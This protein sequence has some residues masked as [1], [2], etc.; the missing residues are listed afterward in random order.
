M[1]IVFLPLL[2]IRRRLDGQFSLE[3]FLKLSD[4]TS[5]PIFAMQK[6]ISELF[7]ENNSH[8]CH[9]WANYLAVYERHLSPFRGKKPVVLEIGVKRG[10]SLALWK[11]YF[12]PES[13]IIGIDIDPSCERFQSHGLDVYIGDQ[14]DEVFLE[15]V[16]SAYQKIDI[17]I[18]DGSHVGSHMIK[19][20]EYIYPRMSNVGIYVVEDVVP[21]V[22][23]SASG[24]E[25]RSF[26]DY[27]CNLANHLNFGFTTKSELRRMDAK[28]QG[29]FSKTGRNTDHYYSGS[30]LKIAP[31]SH[32][33]S[34]T[35]SVM[36]Y[37]NMVVFEK[38]PQGNRSSIKTGKM[39][40]N[41]FEVFS[42]Y[43]AR[44]TPPRSK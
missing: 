19:S 17:V 13:N 40:P 27:A 11:K 35:N 15:K 7:L 9:K 44:V 36:F 22:I 28:A 4:Y 33:T 41:D 8:E 42:A 2:L 43:S 12:G 18:D 37:P 24:E 14:A 25:K 10:G 1:P 6:S 32:F 29:L 34:I 26:V 39:I 3:I 16:L 21:S 31:P 38:L 5:S 30:L 23:A 20:F